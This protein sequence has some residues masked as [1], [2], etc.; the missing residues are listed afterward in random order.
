MIV[1]FLSI[2]SLLIAISYIALITYNLKYW[3]KSK[4]KP[5]GIAAN[6]NNFSIIIVGRN[7]A[8]NIKTCLQSILN[9][10]YPQEKIQIIFVDDHSQDSTLS[11]V[12]SLG[13]LITI[14]ELKNYRSNKIIHY[15]KAAIAYALEHSLGDI[16]I[17]TDADC[18]VRKNW[19]ETINN[20][21]NEGK[22]DFVASPIIINSN[23]KIVQQFQTMDMLGMM[24]V[25]AAG[26]ES[27][28]WY[29]ANG[30]NLAFR[31][32]AVDIL[33]VF[34]NNKHSSGDDISLINY[35]AS[36]GKKV[37]FCNNLEAIVTTDSETSITSLYNQRLRWA[38][39][40]KTAKSSKYILMM[41][42]PYLLSILIM[43][44]LFISIIDF[45]YAT[46]LLVLLFLKFSIDHIY[47]KSISRF[48]EISR[49]MTYFFSSSILHILYIALI[50]TLSMFISKYKWK[51]RITN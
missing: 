50:G 6:E 36:S 14:L 35:Y 40:N 7:E 18:V 47:L 16:I 22:Y 51:G 4:Y 20:F 24:G 45:K 44:F 26:I 23:D 29:M 8:E 10:S 25:T 28:N 48:Y 2:F 3:A 34:S 49:S 46:V 33:N 9:N 11:E 30:A 32:S 5:S 37:G 31:K 42:I 43:T 13:K 1:S 19:I 27:Q 15:K 12:K 39:K 41:S 17:T 21:L 38:T